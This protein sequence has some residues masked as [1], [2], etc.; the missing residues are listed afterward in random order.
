MATSESNSSADAFHATVAKQISAFNSARLMKRVTDGTLKLP[1]YHSIL[2]TIFHQT[3]AAPYT[4]AKRRP[5]ALGATRRL[6]STCWSMR[7]RSA[8]IGDG[9]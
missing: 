2:C 6:R 7:K 5:I 9:C 8:R 3:Y 4:F 1:H